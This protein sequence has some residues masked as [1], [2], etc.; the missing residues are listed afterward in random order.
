[1]CY[2]LSSGRL[3]EN[4]ANST[5]KRLIEGKVI[6]TLAFRRVSDLLTAPM[7]WLL[8]SKNNPFAHEDPTAINPLMSASVVRQ[9]PPHRSSNRFRPS[10]SGSPSSVAAQL[11][12][13]SKEFFCH[14]CHTSVRDL[15]APH[16][17]TTVSLRCPNVRPGSSAQF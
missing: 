17:R 3:D 7:P 10:P 8:F 2:A 5:Q 12:T 4:V 13:N 9:I 6:K 11:P 1:M 14:R 15:R 16:R